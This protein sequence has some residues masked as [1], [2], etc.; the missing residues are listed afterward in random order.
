M[1][2]PEFFQNYDHFYKYISW[3]CLNFSW[4]YIENGHNFERTEDRATVF[5][6]WMDFS[7]LH[8]FLAWKLWLYRRDWY[9]SKFDNKGKQFLGPKWLKRTNVDYWFF[10]QMIS[11]GFRGQKGLIIFGENQ[12]MTTIVNM[13]G[14]I[15]TVLRCCLWLSTKVR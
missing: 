10:K 14:I 1:R 3:L 13:H 15:I 7:R 9:M 11:V 2:D 4:C 12:T 6:K 8:L 5:L